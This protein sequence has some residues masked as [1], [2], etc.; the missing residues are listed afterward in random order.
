MASPAEERYSMIMLEGDG[1]W[2]TWKIQMKALL[3]E[4][5]LWGYVTESIKLKV[6]PSEKYI[7][8]HEH[9]PQ[10]AYT[11][12]IMSL[13]TSCVALCQA[14]VTTNEVWI[15]L[16]IVQERSFCEGCAKG[17]ASHVRPEALNEIRATRRCGIVHIDVLGPVSIESLTGKRFMISFTDDMTRCSQVYFMNL[18]SEAL[19]KFKEYQA[20]VQGTSGEFFTL[21]EEASICRG[22]SNGT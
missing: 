7:E 8:N 19:D 17:K 3:M 20:S 13:S 12:I 16:E 11:K 14:C 1:N 10:C 9:K 18:K 2:R 21:I 22:S 5:K 15:T 6:D 4:K